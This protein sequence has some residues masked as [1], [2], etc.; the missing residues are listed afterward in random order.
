MIVGTATDNRSVSGSGTRL[1]RESDA[2]LSWRM[3]SGSTSAAPPS[4]IAPALVPLGNQPRYVARL[5]NRPLPIV[6]GRFSLDTKQRPLELEG[7]IRLAWFPSPTIQYRGTVVTPDSISLP[8]Q[9]FRLRVPAQDGVG[10]TSLLSWQV[11]PSGLVLSGSVEGP[12]TIGRK[13]PVQSIRLHVPNFH[14]YDGA[15]P[16]RMATDSGDVVERTRITLKFKDWV[17][18][19]DQAIDIDEVQRLLNWY[20][21]YGIGHVGVIERNDRRRFS[22]SEV[23]NLLSCLVRFLTFARGLWCAPIVFE[24]LDANGNVAWVEWESGPFASDWKGVH[25]WLPLKNA[26]AAGEVFSGF[27]ALWADPNWAAVLREAVYWYA[28]ANMNAGAIE[29]GLLLAHATLERLAWTHL[30]VDTKK[31]SK[32]A[33]DAL[34]AHGR[35]RELLKALRIPRGIPPRYAALAVW[36]RKQKTKDGPEAISRLR[37]KLVHPHPPARKVLEVTTA[38]VRRQATWLAL[39]YIELALLALC[40]YQGKYVRRIYRPGSSR[41]AATVMVPWRR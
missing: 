13:R 35:I 9:A 39:W 3:A 5:P 40:R 34:R 8:V 28:E 25:S 6:R 19:I 10:R 2:N 24:G 20:G 17:I 7:T 29:G 31:Y 33:F 14:K 32:A 4:G 23:T 38:P 41:D 26:A 36:A 15:L 37:N 12:L 18:H 11:T 16:V 30:V 22:L 1:L 21:G 27:A